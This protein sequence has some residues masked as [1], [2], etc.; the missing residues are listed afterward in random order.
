MKK[1][2]LDILR[3]IRKSFGRFFSIFAIVAI[4]VAFFAGVK[5]SAPLMKETADAY[6][7]EYNLQDIQV[8]ST[9]GFVDEDIDELRKI[10][11]IEGV[12]ATNSVDAVFMMD[13]TEY[14]YKIMTLPED[15]S[16]SNKDYIN[17]AVLVEG[18]LPESPDECVVEEGQIMA[19]G[20]QV[21]D[22]IQ[23]SSGTDDPLED[24]LNYTELTVV[25]KVKIPYYLS[26]QKGSSSIGDGSLDGFLLT[27][28]E[29]FKSDIY[30][31]VYITVDGAKEYNSYDE[32]YFDEV[33][34]PVTNRIEQL[35]KERASL[36]TEDIKAQALE[37]YQKSEDEFNQQK[38]EVENQL[39]EAEKQLQAG[40]EELLYNENRIKD[41]KS[42]IELIK[43]QGEAQLE[44][45]QTQLELLKAQL[46]MGESN[47]QVQEMQKML[48]EVNQQIDA[49]PEEDKVLTNE[50][51]FDLRMRQQ[52]LE[53]MIE[54]ATSDAT[55]EQLEAAIT[56]QEE[57]I[58]SMKEELNQQLASYEEQI[59]QGEEQVA[60]G[61]IDYE[62]GVQEL[63]NNRRIAQ[64]QL[65]DAQ[66]QLDK[67]KSDIENMSEGEWIVLDRQ[68]HYSYMDYG[69]SADRMDSI[70]KIFPLF[71]FL[72][73]A[74]IC[75][76]TMTRMVDEQRSVIGTFKAL[77]YS[78]SAIA[79]RY[80]SYAFISSVCG[81]VVGV[82]VGFA[83]FPTLITHLWN[84][85]YTL[86]DAHFTFYWDLALMAS[87]SCIAIVLI[88][89]WFAVYKELR[90]TPALLMRPKAPSNG[91]R[92]FLERVTFIWKRLSFTRK[93]TFRNL[94]RYKKRFFMTVIGISGCTALLVA[95][96]GI[97]DSIS[98]IVSNQYEELQ[99]YQV[100]VLIDGDKNVVEKEEI[101]NTIN[102]LDHVDE[103]I[104]IAQQSGSA[105]IKN[106]DQ[107]VDLIIVDDEEAYQDFHV[108]RDRR[109][110]ATVEMP[111]SGVLVS[112]KM[113]NDMGLKVGS[114]FRCTSDGTSVEFTVDGI[115]ENYVGHIVIMNGDTY[116]NTFGLSAKP[117]QLLI[118][119]DESNEENDSALGSALTG[120]DGI[121]SIVFYRGSAESFENMI[122]SLSIVV[123]VL[124]ISAG[125]LAFVV[126]YNL[127]NVNISERVRE[128][129]T[130][131]V[132][133]FYDREVSNYVFRENLLLSL[134]GSL[135]GLALG[136]GLHRL[137][138]AL[139][140]LDNVMFGRTIE[141]KSY[142]ISLIMTMFFSWI[143]ARVMHYKLK[144]IPMV[145]SLKSVE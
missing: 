78:K 32:A 51:Y 10:E 43:T 45:A 106:K 56:A 72:V 59:A 19:E 120:I 57:S 80:L 24:T 142:L 26:Y 20:P 92:I 8:Y 33:I 132:L 76:T 65:T 139:A 82:L 86:P 53:L 21:G 35:G 116:K 90:E 5:A 111:E 131:K 99:K 60:Q 119:M 85:M 39:N 69:S 91:K 102:E 4:G 31:E 133:G 70:A 16:E 114:T 126:L 40:Y 103:T 105:N 74:L 109:T 6:F 49:L 145:E 101:I 54:I 50:D 115:F 64:E 47:A 2:Y 117:T 81:C 73:A 98:G 25:G 138:M 128:I 129:A 3:E 37:E 130:L 77:G 30:T 42:A 28:D 134:I 108:L 118:R 83:V 112:E 23:L 15:M 94:F 63:E 17:Q 46:S 95:G 34:D 75:L 97:Q 123:V 36:R 125:L 93:V 71:F 29:N 58:A 144:K 12:H 104:L 61:R 79:L 121:E 88:A 113:A 27:L 140:E 1:I 96:F 7:D 89:T 110:H 68:S 52:S 127:T 141:L 41:M 67:A 66:E 62:N 14:V 124:V 13:T 44:S 11:G 107:S 143:V 135:A 136:M 87:A 122:S 9:L 84:M 100:S 137:I 18:R 55:R 38:Q 22:V 48:D